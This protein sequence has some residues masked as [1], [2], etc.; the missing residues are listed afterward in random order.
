MLARFLVAAIASTPEGFPNQLAA[1]PPL[2]WR[3]WNGWGPDINQPLVMSMMDA[4]LDPQHGSLASFG[5]TDVG[6]DEGWAACGAG[7]NGSF[8]NGTTKHVIVD[9]GRFPSLSNLVKWPV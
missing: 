3:S 7:A 2:G 4:L 8:R 6:L 5:Y 9:K 1:R